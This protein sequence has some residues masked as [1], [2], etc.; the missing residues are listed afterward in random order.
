MA[1]PSLSKK[2]IELAR[3]GNTILN[4]E[5]RLLFRYFLQE[6]FPKAKGDGFELFTGDEREVVIDVY[7]ESNQDLFNDYMLEDFKTNSLFYF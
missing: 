7:R 3:F 6:L 5:E 2:S 4:A 1:N